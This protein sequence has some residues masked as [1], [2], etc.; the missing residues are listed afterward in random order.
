MEAADDGY[1]SI[2]KVLDVFVGAQKPITRATRRTEQR[3]LRTVKDRAIT[4]TCEFGRS[5]CLKPDA[6][7]SRRL[8]FKRRERHGLP[9]WQCSDRQT[10]VRTPRLQ[11]PSRMKTPTRSWRGPGPIP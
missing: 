11:R 2:T 4:Q 1:A 8:Q 3:G 5:P 6:D 9:V 10:W 7:V